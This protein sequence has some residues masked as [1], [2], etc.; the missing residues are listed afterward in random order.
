MAH[1]LPLTPDELGALTEHFAERYEAT[2][3]FTPNSL[4]T[5]A[6]RPEIVV[7]LGDLITVIWRTGTVPAGMK[8]LVALMASTAAGCRYCQAHESVDAE[9]HGVPREKIAEIWSFE[10]S[11]HFT[12]AERSALRLAQAAS[13]VPNAVTVEHFDQLRL[14]YDEGQIVEIMSTVA[15]FGYL[16]R[17]NDSMATDLET[18]PRSQ[19]LSVLPGWVSGK[20]ESA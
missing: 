3:G 12:D 4:K 10:T 6:R 13:V 2:I 8:A 11:K 1:V 5:M 19:A 9:A 15:L 20:H 18:E 14:F 16:N 7:A 17:W